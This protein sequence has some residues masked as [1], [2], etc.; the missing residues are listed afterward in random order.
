L[1][2]GADWQPFRGAVAFRANCGIAGPG[3]IAGHSFSDHNV[4]CCTDA[5]SGVRG[6][7]ISGNIISGNIGD[8]IG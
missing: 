2:I 6:I 3:V 1:F 5:G 4:A 8:T 7:V